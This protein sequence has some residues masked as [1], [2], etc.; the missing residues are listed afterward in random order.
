M[1]RKSLRKNSIHK[2]KSRK[3]IKSLLA[4]YIIL[5]QDFFSCIGIIAVIIMSIYMLYTFSRTSPSFYSF[6]VEPV[7]SSLNSYTQIAQKLKNIVVTH[8]PK[9]AVA[10]LV[11][12][13][14]KNPS[15]LNSCHTLA[16]LIGRTAY[17]KYKNFDAAMQY[18]DDF[19]GSGYLHGVVEARFKTSLNIYSDMF[20]VCPQTH[21]GAC[22]HAIGHGL[23]Y[24]TQNDLPRAL[25]LCDTFG[26]TDKKKLCSE[27]VFMENFTT[28][29]DVHPSKYLHPNDPF[30]P[31][32]EQ[33]AFYKPV[34]YFYVPIYFLSLT[35]NDYAAA[36][37]WC[38][39]AEPGFSAT[40]MNGAGSRTMKQNLSTPDFVEKLCMNHAEQFVSSCIDGMVGY[41]MINFSSWKMGETLCASLEKTNKPTCLA[42]V[43]SRKY[44]F[45]D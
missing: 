33:N 20:S 7:S 27:G 36:L 16:H 35:H 34:C 18:M 38:K 22:Y 39:T 28:E 9:A 37:E 30:F 17:E 41:Y 15:I 32:R 40:C 21:A 12:A 44:M 8:D 11:D 4:R 13:S 29:V 1:K 2:K 5:K 3:R 10:A 42:A 45:V 19:C 43:S 6:A 23:M 24:F 25:T 26:Q 31:C 14:E